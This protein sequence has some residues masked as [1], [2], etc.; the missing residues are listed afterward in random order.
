MYVH[1]RCAHVT[2]AII[3]NQVSDLLRNDHDLLQ[4][5]TAF[6][7]DNVSK[8]LYLPEGTKGRFERSIGRQKAPNTLA[9]VRTTENVEYSRQCAKSTHVANTISLLPKVWT[10]FTEGVGSYFYLSHGRL[11]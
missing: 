3:D 7:P 6:L 11:R 1:I 10:V 9:D 2:I 5:F 8:N 4:E